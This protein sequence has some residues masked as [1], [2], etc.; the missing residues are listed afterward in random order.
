MSLYAPNQ[1]LVLPCLTYVSYHSASYHGLLCIFLFILSYLP[2]F[3][4]QP[5]LDSHLNCRF[6]KVYGN[7]AIT[8]S[9]SVLTVLGH[10]PQ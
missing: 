2:A 10:F 1:V 8:F 9:S 6:I 5:Y 4:E 7:I 3:V